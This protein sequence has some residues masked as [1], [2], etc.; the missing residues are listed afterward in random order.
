VVLGAVH[1]PTSKTNNREA[2]KITW[3]FAIGRYY[4]V[5]GAV[6]TVSLDSP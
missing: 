6:Q 1:A 5:R 3:Y 4:K 2:G